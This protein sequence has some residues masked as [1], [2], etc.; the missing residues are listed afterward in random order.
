M[1]L[2]FIKVRTQKESRLKN[3]R[4]GRLTSVLDLPSLRCSITSM[5]RGKK[6]ILKG[7]F[8]RWKKN[9]RIISLKGA[10]RRGS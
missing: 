4:E 8:K 2:V 10:D 6:G 9:F 3:G 7:N 1:V 5:K